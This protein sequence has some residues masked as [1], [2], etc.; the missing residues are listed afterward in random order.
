MAVNLN[1]KSLLVFVTLIALIIIAIWPKGVKI[2]DVPD[3]NSVLLSNGATVRLIGVSS[4]REG[5][6]DLSTLKGKVVELQPD[7]SC[8]FDPDHMNKDQTYYAYVLLKSNQYECLNATLLKKGLALLVENSYLTDSL[9]DFRKYTERLRGKGIPEPEPYYQ[10][11]DYDEEEFSLP[12]IPDPALLRS[13]RRFQNWST[14]RD[15]NVDLLKE[16]CDYNLPYTKQFANHLAANN[17]GNFSPEQI[18]DVFEYCY[19]K[20]RYVNDPS[21]QEYLSKASETI[22][23][24]LIGDCDDFAVLMASCILAIGGDAAIVLA[25][26]AES[27]HAYAEVDISSFDEN[28][29]RNVIR[30]RFS[31]YDHAFNF[32]KDGQHQWLNLD[33]QSAYPGGNYYSS[34]RRYIYSCVSGVWAYN[35]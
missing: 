7:T 27:G 31:G 6:S 29:V 13:E 2:R 24:S 32:R 17:P 16:A 20:W 30:N 9:S 25:Y 19:N 21:G 8:P 15:L 33:W 18:C 35:P 12:Y 23:G 3:G 10:K 5:Q 11:I 26:N 22:Y 28:Y 1:S 34:T 4:S 14:N